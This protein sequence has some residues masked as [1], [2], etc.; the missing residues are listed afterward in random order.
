LCLSP[1]VHACIQ[2]HIYDMLRASASCMQIL[3]ILSIILKGP[4][5]CMHY[6]LMQCLWINRSINR[7]PTCCMHCLMMYRSPCLLAAA[8]ATL[9]TEILAHIWLLQREFHAYRLW[10][11]CL[12]LFVVIV[13]SLAKLLI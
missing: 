13:H 12:I 6:M 4:A 5:G 2:V 10:D 8:V 3:H 9:N 7:S 11:L 1:T